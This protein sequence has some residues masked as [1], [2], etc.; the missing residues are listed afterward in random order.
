MDRVAWISIGLLV[1]LPLLMRL[2]SRRIHS[3]ESRREAKLPATGGVEQA[4]R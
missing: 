4:G 2:V 3:D 1:P